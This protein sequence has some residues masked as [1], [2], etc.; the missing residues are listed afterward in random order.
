MSST[1]AAEY[2][3]FYVPILKWKQ[4]EQHALRQ[5]HGLD[6]A[7]TLPLIELQ[8]VSA[9]TKL[10]LAEA[11]KLAVG[12]SSEALVK[13]SGKEYPVAIDTHMVIPTYSSQ[14]N[15][16]FAVCQRLTKDGLIVWPVLTP[17]ILVDAKANLA[18]FA[19]YN[20]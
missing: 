14:A 3:F 8:P 13:A 16:L 7:G 18:R 11:L 2:E 12:K 19:V 20:D 9:T 6:R 1:Y 17:E 10:N 15:L 5:L 4:G